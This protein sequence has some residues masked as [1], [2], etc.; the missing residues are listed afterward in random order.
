MADGELAKAEIETF[1]LLKLWKRGKLVL[2][3]PKEV[4]LLLLFYFL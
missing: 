4:L 1:L 2:L 3:N